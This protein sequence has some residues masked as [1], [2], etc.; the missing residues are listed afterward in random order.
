MVTNNVM[1]TKVVS[2]ISRNKQFLIKTVNFS[3][4]NSFKCPPPNQSFLGS[5]IGSISYPLKLYKLTWL[6]SSKT[7]LNGP[8]E[9]E[10]LYFLN[11]NLDLLL[12]KFQ[13]LYLTYL[14]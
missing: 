6:D 1:P 8:I 10:F 2:S 4:P 11:E 5:I 9:F 7:T 12:N 13:K 3:A 14:L